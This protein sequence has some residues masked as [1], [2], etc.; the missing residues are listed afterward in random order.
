[1]EGGGGTWRRRSRSESGKEQRGIN[2]PAFGGNRGLT[3]IDW[4][5]NLFY[6]GACSLVKKKKQKKKKKELAN[7]HR[8]T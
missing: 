4:S 7:R 2:N 8:E 6:L 1:M 3:A 5:L